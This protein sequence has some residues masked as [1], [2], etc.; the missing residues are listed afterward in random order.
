MCRPF[1]FLVI[2]S[3]LPFLW[4]APAKDP[5]VC[6]LTETAVIAPCYTFFFP[7]IP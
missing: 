4:E 3:Q 5:T 2:L 6:R 7:H 1:L